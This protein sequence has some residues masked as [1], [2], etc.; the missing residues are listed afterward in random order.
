MPPRFLQKG[1][2]HMYSHSGLLPQLTPNA[3]LD[4]INHEGQMESVETGNDSPN[5]PPGLLA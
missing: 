2:H 5:S 4:F 1:A 3:S